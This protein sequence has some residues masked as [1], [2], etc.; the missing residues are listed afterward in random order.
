MAIPVLPFGE[1][2]F[3]RFFDET[4]LT[5]FLFLFDFFAVE[6]FILIMFFKNNYNKNMPYRKTAD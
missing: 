5:G 6:D 1:A 4:V 2:R 3:V